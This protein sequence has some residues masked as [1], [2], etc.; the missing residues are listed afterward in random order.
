MCSP[1]AEAR[2]TVELVRGDWVLTSSCP[3][4]AA[5]SLH[6][7]HVSVGERAGSTAGG[8]PPSDERYRAVRPTGGQGRE[9]CA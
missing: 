6:P 3:P 4:P 5:P 2:G 1:E 7:E 8:V 9:V